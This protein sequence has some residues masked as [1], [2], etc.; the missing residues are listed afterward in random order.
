MNVLLIS[1]C[2]FFDFIPFPPPEIELD[3]LGGDGGGIGNVQVWGVLEVSVVRLTE[4]GL[5]GMGFSGTGRN[6]GSF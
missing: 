6:S 2:V 4:M 3:K 1:A 5:A